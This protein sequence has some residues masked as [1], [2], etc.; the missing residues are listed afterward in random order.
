MTEIRWSCRLDERLLAL[1]LRSDEAATDN[2]WQLWA[3]W[4]QWRVALTMRRLEFTPD[5]PVQSG[6]WRLLCARIPDR[7]A[8]ARP[9]G[10]LT[11]TVG[12]R[13]HLLDPDRGD[14]GPAEL[15]AEIRALFG[16][17]MAGRTPAFLSG[18]ATSL[19][20]ELTPELA[21]NLHQ[22]RNTLR[23][24]LPQTKIEPGPISAR[25]EQVTAI[26]QHTFWLTGWIH[27]TNPRQTKLTAIT[28]EGAR[29]QP[30]PG[31][32]T[33]HPRP[34]YVKALDD[35]HTTTLGFHTLIQTPTP[36]IHPHG[37]TL[38]LQA[39]NG[40]HVQDTARQ[41]TN[42]DATALWDHILDALHTEPHNDERLQQQILAALEHLR[43][44][45]PNDQRP[46]LTASPIQDLE[47]IADEPAPGSLAATVSL[48][49]RDTK[50]DA[51]AHTYA[52]AVEGT[53]SGSDRDQVTI[54]AT[55]GGVVLHRSHANI[56][57]DNLI[58]HTGDGTPS[59]ASGFQLVIG[60][61]ALAPRFEVQ[62]DAVSAAGATKLGTVR[63]RR[64]VLATRYRPT[65][66]PL[67]V[68]TMGRSGSS[69][70]MTLLSCHPE[71]VVYDP[72]PYEARLADY[73]MQVLRT[74]SE[75]VSYMQTILPLIYNDEWWV[76]SERPEPPP[77]RAPE[78]AMPRW[79][80]LEHPQA[81][82]EFCQR[83][84]EG[85]YAALA[86]N[87]GR[88]SCRYFAEKAFPGCTAQLIGELYPEGRQLVLV[89]DFRD[90][91]CSIREFNRRMGL[92]QWRRSASNNDAEWIHGLRPMAD[93]MM[94]GWQGQAKLVR[95][96]DLVA[97]PLATM[98][99]VCRYLGVD[100]DSTRLDHLVADAGGAIPPKH[101]AERSTSASVER[102]IGRWKRE[103][104]P[105][106][107]V[108][109]ADA[110]EDL[111]T[112][113]GYEPTFS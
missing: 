10:P 44:V 41:P 12:D 23:Q 13:E 62:I 85:F 28:P 91:F 101:R 71:V 49:P 30:N 14:T 2:R 32:T 110:F 1:L 33:Y 109:C 8:D 76:G 82:A 26:D 36:S 92:E 18:L 60:S 25:L 40:R 16:P 61:L 100:A 70:L 39:T 52:F 75:P 15:A 53:V 27:E 89:R 56:P 78:A 94:L 43:Q 55:H 57:L 112:E 87:Q 88:A 29:V 84:L 31:A 54:E 38:E 58:E 35:A 73:W 113:F 79:L 107:R 93:Q 111:L 46:P 90:M 6:W 7:L 9:L 4:Q 34:A 102:S 98:I 19:E 48:P 72:I 74:L 63:G 105:E 21:A 59:E 64:R 81:L 42:P 5:G 24:P 47:L 45:V 83:R 104:S 37:W 86:L 80:G 51:F 106:L 20:I 108:A 3:R 69:W 50:S 65:L 68:R 99:D 96:E 22:I 66:Q 67:M 17:Q 77:L 11:L 103:L 97:D 95:Y